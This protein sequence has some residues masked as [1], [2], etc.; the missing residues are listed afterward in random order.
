MKAMCK[1][2]FHFPWLVLV[3]SFV[4]LFVC[5]IVWFSDLLGL[6]EKD[7]QQEFEGRV[8]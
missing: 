5:V 6:M 7:S 2:L 3:F 8:H 4:C 1:Y